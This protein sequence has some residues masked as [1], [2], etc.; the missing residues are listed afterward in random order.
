MIDKNQ[1]DICGRGY[2]IFSV[3]V[4]YGRVGYD[5]ILGKV[6]LNFTDTLKPPAYCPQ[7][8]RALKEMEKV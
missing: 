6:K 7:C 2:E 5:D 8:G 3:T 4:R 1:C